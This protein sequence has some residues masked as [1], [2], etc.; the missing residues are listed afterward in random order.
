MGA[1]GIG[2]HHSNHAA[3]GFFAFL[4]R[5]HANFHRRIV[6]ERS[7]LLGTAG[8]GLSTS[9]AGQGHE[10]ALTR[11]QFSGKTTE[12]RAVGYRLRHLR[13]TQLAAGSLSYAVMKRLLA[14]R[15]AMAARLIA[16][17]YH[18]G[19]FRIVLLGIVG[20]RRRIP[21]QQN[22]SGRTRTKRAQ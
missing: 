14:C 16:L 19:M 13:M 3:T 9:L 17:L 8:T 12:C 11:E 7:A 21:R 5:V 1:R 2:T 6:G 15:L 4:A 22:Q 10:C 20:R 18:R